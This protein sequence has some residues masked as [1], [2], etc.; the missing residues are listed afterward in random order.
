MRAVAKKGTIT[1]QEL[2]AAIDRATGRVTATPAP[3][4][5]TILVVDD[6]DLN[7]ELA[8][9]ILEHMGY[10]V[11]LA[12]D[13]DAGIALAIAHK[14][15]LVLMDLA[16]P[17][18]D[19]F[20]AAKELKKNKVTESI[21]IVALT[22]MAMRGDEVKAFEAGMDDYLTKPIDRKALES[23]LVRFVG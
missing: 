22:A 13:G 14:P 1:R 5:K 15:A 9:S 21:P 2:L 7:R 4:A 8:R 18:K 20:A 23:V 16:M 3:T 12:G 17:K 11:L 6:H 10:H 19:G